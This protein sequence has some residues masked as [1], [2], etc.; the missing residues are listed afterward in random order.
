MDETQAQLAAQATQ[1]GPTV[2][3]SHLAQFTQIVL[4]KQMPRRSAPAPDD[5]QSFSDLP[6]ARVEA[7]F[8]GI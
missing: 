2:E 7:R 8:T 3:E 6:P 4:P 5:F 1:I